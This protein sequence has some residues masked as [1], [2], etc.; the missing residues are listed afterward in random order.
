VDCPRC[1]NAIALARFAESDD[2]HGMAVG[3]CPACS[4]RVNLPSG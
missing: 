3:V 4:E 1:G 2:E